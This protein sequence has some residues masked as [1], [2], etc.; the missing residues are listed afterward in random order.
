ME[1]HFKFI[2]P[3]LIAGAFIIAFAIP[4]VVENEYYLHTFIVSGVY[5]LLALGLNLI[6]G[7]TG[8]LS[9]GHAAFYG[10]GAYTSTLLVMKLHFSFWLALPCAGLAGGIAGIMLGFPALRLKGPYLVICTIAFVEIAHQIF[11]NW[12]S[13]TRGPMGITGIPSPENV[14]IGSFIIDF[15]EKQAYYYLVL[16]IVIISLL[17]N[18]SLIRSKTGRALVAIRED[19]IAAAV[20]GINLTF[21]KLIAF[22]GATF[23]AGIAGS[24]YAHYIGFVSPES[25][26]LGESINILIMVV[27]GGM[28]TLIGPVFGSIGLTFLLEFMRAFAEYRMIIYGILLMILIVVLPEGT[29]GGIEI[30]RRSIKKPQ[31]ASNR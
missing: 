5:I 30:L 18:I 2:K 9:L 17:L 28:G 24:L 22:F 21:Y 16:I 12:E 25:F 19:Q 31:K 1:K 27:V 4:L 14:S 13:L 11:M 6:L 3:I 7:Y 29:M 8:H 20:M 23:L 26:T 10:I 15:S